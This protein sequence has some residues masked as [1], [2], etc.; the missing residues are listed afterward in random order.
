VP[1]RAYYRKDLGLAQ[2]QTA[3]RLYFDSTDRGSVITL[4]GAADEIFGKLLE[5]SGR[6]SSLKSLI[7]AV[8][9]IQQ[10]L[11]GEALEP[12]HIADRA[13][14]ARNSLKHWD[15]GDTEIVVFDLEIEAR[16]MLNRAID[17]YWMLEHELTPEMERFQ[18]ELRVA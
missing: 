8:A 2:L 11:F 6:T 9:E 17:N 4:A 13:N 3:L 16:D 18:R 5:A 10:K 14:A 1:V 7:T 15:I 12:K